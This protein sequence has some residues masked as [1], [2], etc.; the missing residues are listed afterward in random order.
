MEN[1]AKVLVTLGD[2]GLTAFIIYQILDTVEIF[3]FLGLFTWGIRTVWKAWKKHE[4]N[5]E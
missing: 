1:L 5:E 4:W 2:K 3:V